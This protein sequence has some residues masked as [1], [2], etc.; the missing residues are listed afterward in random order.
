MCWVGEEAE[1]VVTLLAGRQ[2]DVV[3]R[4]PEIEEIVR[5]L[6]GLRKGERRIA[7]RLLEGWEA[8]SPICVLGLGPTFS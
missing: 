4:R 2:T 8:G 5:G 3:L 6:S 7:T 1:Q